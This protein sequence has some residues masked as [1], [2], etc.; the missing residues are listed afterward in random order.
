MA[1]TSISSGSN[2]L[3]N[4]QKIKKMGGLNMPIVLIL[5]ALAEAAI[6]FY[7]AKKAIDALISKKG[8]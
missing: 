2:S 8:E 5:E 7:V 1:S 6:E 4:M 3:A